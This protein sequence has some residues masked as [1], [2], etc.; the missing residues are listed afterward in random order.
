MFNGESRIDFRLSKWLLKIL[1][2][3]RY[4][5]VFVGHNYQ[6]ML[7]ITIKAFQW[8]SLR[9]S[10]KFKVKV[11]FLSLSGV[12]VQVAALPPYI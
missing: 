4:Y 1:S 3:Y 11:L 10:Q 12:E 8:H 2:I 6:F 9:D 5:L 7:V